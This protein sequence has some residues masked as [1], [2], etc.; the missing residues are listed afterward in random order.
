MG[1]AG[2]EDALGAHATQGDGEPVGTES[3]GQY[4]VQVM[5]MAVAP[6]KKVAMPGS[7]SGPAAPVPPR[8]ASRA[9]GP[10]EAAKGL[11]VAWTCHWPGAVALG[12]YTRCRDAPACFQCGAPLMVGD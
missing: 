6:A 12:R 10:N 3:A 2:H 4:A 11:S 8:A 5:F 7:T 9:T 1:A